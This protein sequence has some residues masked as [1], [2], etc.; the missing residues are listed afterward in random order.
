MQEQSDQDN[1]RIIYICIFMKHFSVVKFLC[2]L[3]QTFMVSKNLG[4]LQY[5]VPKLVEV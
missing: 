5:S 3:Q 1:D 2:S 4:N